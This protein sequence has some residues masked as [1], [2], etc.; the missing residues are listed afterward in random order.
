M[1]KNFYTYF[2]K[3]IT[4][5][6][7]PKEKTNELVIKKSTEL[8]DTLVIYVLVSIIGY[9]IIPKVQVIPHLYILTIHY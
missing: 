2:L 5:K 1:R 6:K 3:N 4:N 7:K 9:V 8:N